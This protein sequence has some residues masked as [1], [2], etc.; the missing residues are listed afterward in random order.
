MRTVRKK[1]GSK[2]VDRGWIYR[3][4]GLETSRW[5]SGYWCAIM[6]K[7]RLLSCRSARASLSSSSP[8]NA[9]IHRTLARRRGCTARENVWMGNA[10]D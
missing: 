9:L 1:P 10:R 8:T 2:Y 3:T 5:L 4:K 6:C 7:L